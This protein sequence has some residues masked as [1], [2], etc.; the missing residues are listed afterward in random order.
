M[1]TLR[2]KSIA[3]LPPHLSA[4]LHVEPHKRSK[5]RNIKTVVNGIMF[6]SRKEADYYRQL[7][8]L[9]ATDAIRGFVRQVSLLLPSGRRLRL[10]FVVIENDGRVRWID[11][12]GYATTAWCIK[13][14]EAQAALGIVIETV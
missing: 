7:L 2:F 4:A 3:D 12:K 13:K 6:D 11:V 1:R 10:D 9:K 8:L 5:Y 14:D